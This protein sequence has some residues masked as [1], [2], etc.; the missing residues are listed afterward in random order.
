[1]VIMN[2][3]ATTC[4]SSGMGITFVRRCEWQRIHVSIFVQ[5]VPSQEWVALSWLERVALSNV[6]DVV[7]DWGT[8]LDL[9]DGPN[10]PPRRKVTALQ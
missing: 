2:N 1:M 10:H 7:I 9:M 4:P 6:T 8:T 5:P 3:G